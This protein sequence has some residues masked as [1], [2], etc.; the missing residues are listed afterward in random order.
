MTEGVD[1][2]LNFR[3]DVKGSPSGEILH[4]FSPP[5]RRE[6]YKWQGALLFM[7]APAFIIFIPPLFCKYF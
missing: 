3:H 6:E 4:I 1:S 2:R 7:L 5:A